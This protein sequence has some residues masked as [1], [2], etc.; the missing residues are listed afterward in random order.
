MITARDVASWFGALSAAELS[1]GPS[2]LKNDADGLALRRSNSCQIVA[3]MPGLLVA[4]QV[5]VS[6]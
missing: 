2:F 3:L 6:T 4:S 1:R 5:V